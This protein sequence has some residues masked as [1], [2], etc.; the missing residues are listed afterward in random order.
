MKTASFGSRLRALREEKKFGLRELASKAGISPAFLSKVESG[1]EKP[2]AEGKLRALAKTL[3]YDPEVLM[4]LAGRLPTDIVEII[5]RHPSQYV[6][7]LRALRLRSAEQL[8]GLRVYLS[9]LEKPHTIPSVEQ[10]IEI[11]KSWEGN[12]IAA[13]LS[14][15]ENRPSA[16]RRTRTTEGWTKASKEGGKQ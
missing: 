8:N 12:K 5:Q 10:L 15:L 13:R 14:T 4:A 9:R 7:L 11:A 16:G 1:K 3:D 6:A 2:P